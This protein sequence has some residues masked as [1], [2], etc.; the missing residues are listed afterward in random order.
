MVQSS[1]NFIPIFPVSKINTTNFKFSMAEV[2]ASQLSVDLTVEIGND[3]DCDE[4]ADEKSCQ[5][6]SVCSDE[7]DTTDLVN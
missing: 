6:A 7:R 5:R 2:I 4:I 3:G 1:H